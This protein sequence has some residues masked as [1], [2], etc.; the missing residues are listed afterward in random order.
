M[1]TDSL[2]VRGLN[3]EQRAAVL[4]TRG[5]VLILAGAGSGKTRVITT[6][7]AYLLE[8]RLAQPEEILAVTFT[9]KA[10]TEM[11]ERVAKIVGDDLARGIVLSTFHSFCVRVLRTEIEHIGYRRNFTISTEGDTRTL[12]RRTLQDLD[13]VNESFD[14]GAFISRIGMMKSGVALDEQVPEAVS[15]KPEADEKRAE[16]AAKYEKWLP[17][18]YERYQSA[19]RA[20]NAVDFDDLLLLTLQL[21]REHPRVLA[22]FQ[23]Q[24][25]YIMVDEYQDTNRTQYDL[26]RFLADRH[27]NLCVVGDDDQSIYSWRGADISNILNFEKDFPEAKVI[28]LEQNYRSTESILNAA[29]RVIANNKA[30]RQK[31]LWSALGKGTPIDWFITGDEEHE[32]REVVGYL[33]HIREQTGAGY[34]RFAVLYRSNLQSR[35]FEIAMRQAGIPYVVV[36]GQDF[37][38]RTEIRDLVA[39]LKLIANP[40]DE[41]S[42]LRVVNVP[43]RGIGDGTLH[44][45]HEHCLKENVSL[46]KGLAAVLKEGG[47]ASNTEAGIRQFLGVINEFRTR[48]KECRGRLGATAMELVEHIGYRADLDRNC[49]SP[50]QFQMRWNNVEALMSAI[51]DYESKHESPTLSGF[52][53]QSALVT[54]DDRRDADK[55]TANAVTLLTIHSAKGLEFPFVFLVG[56]EEGLLPHSR[57]I[58]DRAIEEERRLFYVAVTRAQRHL[59]I[60]EALSRDRFGKQRLTKTSR[61]VAEIPEEL[62]RKRIR[63][64]RDMVEAAVDPGPVKRP[65]RPPR[66]RR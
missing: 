10:A 56:A 19:L 61:F 42:F 8:Q 26:L 39:Y 51:A 34:N 21:W 14:V 64:A 46:G 11:R 25:R 16:T 41:A 1:S 24:F 35:P 4:Q 57:S 22:R 23:K 48:F 54:D 45:V 28:K 62:L 9:N 20:A 47:L 12:L 17:E 43:R 6:R 59:A 13:G 55:K 36:G 44:Q 15:D 63:A 7:I 58:G 33:E 31:N 40:R 66:K 2:L 27:H 3:P 18:I 52:L 32:A 38:E 29:N 37:F 49:K 30:R 5:P 60:F 53:D 65:K 50:E